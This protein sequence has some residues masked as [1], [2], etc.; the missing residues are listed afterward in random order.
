MSATAIKRNTIL[1]LF[2]QHPDLLKSGKVEVANSR[3]WRT[4][5]K[6]IRLGYISNNGKITHKG[7]QYLEKNNITHTAP[8]VA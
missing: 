6:A 7:Y 2:L 8:P 3:Q 4:F 5:N 1:N